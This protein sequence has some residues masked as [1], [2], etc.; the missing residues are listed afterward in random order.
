MFR[1]TMQIKCKPGGKRFDALK[2]QT[3]GFVIKI[4]TLQRVKF[5]STSIYII[6]LYDALLYSCITSHKVQVM[7]KRQ[8]RKKVQK[9]INSP[10]VEMIRGDLTSEIVAPRFCVTSGSPTVCP[11]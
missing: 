4:K 8:G 11:E 9:L 7:K 5:M 6:L 2:N 10:G 3:A 1:S